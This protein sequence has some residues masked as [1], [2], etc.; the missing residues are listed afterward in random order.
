MCTPTQREILLHIIGGNRAVL[1]EYFHKE[2]LDVWS[3]TDADARCL[4]RYEAEDG[5]SLIEQGLVKKEDPYLVVN[6]LLLTPAGRVVG[7]QVKAITE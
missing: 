3:G 5:F 2:V 6:L 7:K 4:A 1:S